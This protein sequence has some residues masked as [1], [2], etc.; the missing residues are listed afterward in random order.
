MAR[1]TWENA[2]VAEG[3]DIV[4][5]EGNSYFRK[6]DIHW[7]YF[8]PNSETTICPWKGT[9]NYYDVEVGGKVNP[10]A[11]WYYADP[12]PEAKEILG[13]VAFWKGVVVEPS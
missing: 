5:V 2:T 3:D 13:R 12:K 11:A 4:I 1:A 9:A 8:K 6:E 10:G 7:Q